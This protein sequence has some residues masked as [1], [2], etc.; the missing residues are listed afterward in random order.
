MLAAPGIDVNAA[1][2][3]GETPLWKA[4]D[5]AREEMVSQLFATPGIDANAANEYGITPLWKAVK[6]NKRVV[7]D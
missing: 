2:R 4:A 7:V 5:I 6:S 1:N 3:C